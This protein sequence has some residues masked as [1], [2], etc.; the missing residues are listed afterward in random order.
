MAS[1]GLQTKKGANH[2]GHF[3]QPTN[4]NVAALQEDVLYHFHLSTSTHDLPAMF[5]DVKFVCIGGSPTRMEAFI[6]YMAK[7]LGLD[8]PGAEYPNM[9]V[10]TDRYVM[11]KVGPVLSVS[12]GIGIPSTSIMLHEL[13][14][15]L[16]HARCSDVTLIRIG[17]SGG[18]GLE[19]GSVVITRQA[20]DASFQPVFEQM[21]LG[22]RV[23]HRTHLDERLAQELMQ[24]GADL[25]EFPTVLGNTMCTSD[26]YE[27]QGRLDGALCS[28]TEKDKQQYLRAAHAAGVRNIEMESSVLAV[29]CGAC[30]LQAAVVCV[31]LLNRLEGDQVSSP[32]EVLAEY[33]KRPQRLVG[34]FI[35]KRL[36]AAGHPLNL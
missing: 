15:L 29:M 19:P 34:H 18:I 17:T 3:V 14:K 6:K 20:V 10:G 30:G 31:T 35:K 24:C 23:V 28:Y 21:V 9:C 4:P 2:N 13:I 36:A 27:G 16:Y 32:H 11:F 1:S 8:R 12:H 22:K 7:E 25:H 5:G 26:F 33:Q